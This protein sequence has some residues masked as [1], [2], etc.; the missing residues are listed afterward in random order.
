MKVIWQEHINSEWVDCES[1]DLRPCEAKTF[2]Q[3]L[4]RQ[5]VVEI[6]EVAFCA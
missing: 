4:R 3:Y 2:E 6:R 1:D 5:D